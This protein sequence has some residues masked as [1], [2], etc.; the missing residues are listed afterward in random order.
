MGFFLAAG[1]GPPRSAGQ[2]EALLGASPAKLAQSS[3]THSLQSENQA[4]LPAPRRKEETQDHAE[5]AE[6]PGDRSHSLRPRPPSAWSPLPLQ[7]LFPVSNFFPLCFHSW[8]HSRSVQSC[9]CSPSPCKRLSLPPAPFLA[10]T[11]ISTEEDLAGSHHTQLECLLEASAVSDLRIQ[12]DQGA[13]P[14][15]IDRSQHPHSLAIMWG[16]L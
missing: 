13:G 12:Y 16:L 6:E 5:A 3:Q 10:F 8:L 4:M 9:C 14:A 15:G 2:Q 7:T 1:L 11:L